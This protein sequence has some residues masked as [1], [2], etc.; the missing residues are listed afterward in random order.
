MR[1]I[2]I[3]LLIASLATTAAAY[4]T[5]G[6][7]LYSADISTGEAR[8][9]G[10]ISVAGNLSKTPLSDFGYAWPVEV[11]RF[12]KINFTLP[13]VAIE[14]CH[15]EV[16]EKGMLLDLS[17]TNP[18][19]ITNDKKIQ[20]LK[21]AIKTNQY[22]LDKQLLH[23]GNN[24]LKI[25]GFHH[26]LA[27]QTV[28][29]QCQYPLPTLKHE[30]GQSITLLSPVINQHID[31][32]Q[33]ITIEWGST[34]L[35]AHS[36][37]DLDYLDN[38]GQWQTITKG[39]A[40][41]HP[42]GVGNRGLYVWEALPDDVNPQLQ[43]RINYDPKQPKKGEIWEEKLTGMK[44][45]YIPSACLR[46]KIEISEKVVQL[47]GIEL[48]P[49]KYAFEYNC[50]DGFWMAQTEVTNAQYRRFM[51]NHQSG[52]GL[53][54]ANQ[55]VVNVTSIQ[56][57]E[58][59]NWLSTQTGES[60][61][62]PTNEKWMYATLGGKNTIELNI[63]HKL[64]K[65]CEYNVSDLS[66][67]DLY[68]DLDL[69]NATLGEEDVVCGD[70][71]LSMIAITHFRKNAFGLYNMTCNVPEWNCDNSSDCI[72]THAYYA[73]CFPIHDIHNKEVKTCSKNG[74]F[75]TNRG[76]SFQELGHNTMIFNQFEEKAR[77]DYG[78]RLVREVSDRD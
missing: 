66:L 30:K 2:S 48:P 6:N 59:A 35:P 74:D 52:E 14:N 41:N 40:Y 63:L 78:F 45:I 15:L 54:A 16:R 55:P 12:F 38:A 67:I 23:P 3:L 64:T 27:I 49:D 60:F 13:E 75:P 43:V 7:L 10:K 33:P 29:I 5:H 28:V 24:E 32:A 1:Q 21:E 57:E 72:I 68:L 26:N 69:M 50:I 20:F 61:S 8:Y 46:G 9:F 47:L 65:A 25:A 53:N 19:L 58:F 51:H 71:Y 22:D 39:V 56:A 42:T 31:K 62:L 76:D 44:F 11:G 77:S 34:G 17:R 73:S 37:L 36:L 70:C 4:P 18:I